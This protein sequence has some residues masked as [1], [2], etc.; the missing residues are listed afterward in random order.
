MAGLSEYLWKLEQPAAACA[1]IYYVGAINRPG[2]EGPWNI[3]EFYGKSYFCDPRG[4][5][6]AQAG[7]DTDE[8]VVAELDFDLILEVRNTWQFFRDRRPETYEDMS[9]LLP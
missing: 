1:N 6:V 4:Q 9:R 8:V 2:T 5:I 3:G 7:R